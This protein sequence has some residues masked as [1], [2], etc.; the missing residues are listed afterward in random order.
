MWNFVGVY[1]GSKSHALIAPPPLSFIQMTWIIVIAIFCFLLWYYWNDAI[2]SKQRVPSSIPRLPGSYPVV[3]ALI[4]SLLHSNLIN[5][6]LDEVMNTTEFK[7]GVLTMPFSEP[8]L[9]INDPKSL[10]YVLSSKFDNFQKSDFIFARTTDVLGHGIFAV[11]SEEWYWQRKVAA[12]IF[13]TKSFKTTFETV[14]LD[15]IELLLDS[16]RNAS[17]R[18]ETIDMQDLFYRF[19]LDSFG[20]VAFGTAIG[21]MIAPVEFS[22]AFDRS[23]VT[24]NFRFFNPFW[25]LFEPS[26]SGK[27]FAVVRDFGRKIIAERKRHPVQKE[28]PDLLDLFMAYTNENGEHLSDEQLVDQVIN[29]IIAGRDTTAQALSWTL[30]CLTKNPHVVSKVVEEAN[31]IMKDSRIPTYDQVRQ[32]KYALAVFR[33]T[34]RLYPS[35]SRNA[36]VAMTDEVLPNGIVV[37]KGVVVTWSAYAMGR[38]PRIWENPHE[39]IPERWLTDKLPTPF[40]FLAFNAGPRI[41]LGKTLA[42]L[43]GVFVLVS[44]LKNYSLVVQDL[45]RVTYEIAL[46]N[47]IKN[48]LACVINSV[49]Y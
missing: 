21:S 42:E 33:E 25:K 43:Q 12:K 45:E 5:E 39:F 19:F 29:F 46:T 47:P 3:G 11:D 48:G 38:N 16:L 15:N 18:A 23:Q 1:I 13:T 40:E 24:V 28:R 36:K 49:M 44:M 10:E 7:A 4:N 32:M 34:L 2:F 27:D 22:K 8:Y 9:F 6:Y 31:D 37:P 17:E 41:C 26:S 35:V 30:F 14:F 20:Q